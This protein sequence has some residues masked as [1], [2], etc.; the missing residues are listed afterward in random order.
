MLGEFPWVVKAGDTAEVD[1]F[2]HPPLML[3]RERTGAGDHVVGR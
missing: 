1:D 2:V 3:T